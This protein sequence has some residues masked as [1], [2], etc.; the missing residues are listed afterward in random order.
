MEIRRRRDI[1]SSGNGHPPGADGSDGNLPL[2]KD[3]STGLPKILVMDWANFSGM[4]YTEQTMF[5]VIGILDGEPKITTNLAYLKHLLK[6]QT[7]PTA[8]TEKEK[9]KAQVEYTGHGPL[10]ERICIASEDLINVLS[11]VVD[12][13]IDTMNTDAI[14]NLVLLRPYRVLCYYSDE[15]RAT[16]QALIEEEERLFAEEAKEEEAK[17]EGKANPSS[18]KSGNTA[19]AEDTPPSTDDTTKLPAYAP[20]ST[21]AK[22]DADAD[23][24]AD[25]ASVSDGRYQP[26]VVSAKLRKYKNAKKERDDVECLI[27]F[28]KNCFDKR[29]SWLRS[30]RCEKIH[31]SDI[32]HMYKPGNNVISG[33]GKQAYQVI[34]VD[35]D[36]HLGKDPYSEFSRWKDDPRYRYDAETADALIRC[37]FID[38]DGTSLDPVIEQFIIKKFDGE[39][40]VAAMEILPL[41]NYRTPDLARKLAGLK[42]DAATAQSLIAEEVDKFQ[43]RLIERGRC[44]AHVLLGPD[45][46]Q[47]RRG[48]EPSY[49]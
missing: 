4:F 6:M 3:S 44:Q 34:S 16:R 40:L 33:S 36:E 43:K 2:G 20:T 15:I 13:E 47:A 5:S 27:A 31:F 28:M 49:D 1:V 46:R 17:A 38:H 35:P 32:W 9:E 30:G 10:P 45:G 39:R 21:D 48:G 23:S 42:D 22:L 11:G 24:D 41:R 29:I 37:A 18:E 26:S 14:A 19:A 8:T 12:A 7:A 25:S